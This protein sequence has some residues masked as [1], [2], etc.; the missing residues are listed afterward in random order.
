L[1][2]DDS[3]EGDGAVVVDV[4]RGGAAAEAGIR[5]GDVIVSV[6][7]TRVAGAADYQ[8]AVRQARPGSTLTILVQRGDANIYFALRAR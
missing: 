2:V 1:V 8:R 6:N 4:S 5:R 7:R 3:E